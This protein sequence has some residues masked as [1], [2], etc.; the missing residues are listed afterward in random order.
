[1][2]GLG[3][4]SSFRKRSA[5][6]TVFY[7]GGI[8][9][10]VKNKVI[11]P[12]DISPYP[13]P[14]EMSAAVILSR[15]FN[16]D[17]YFIKRSPLKTADVKIENISWEIKSPTG[18]GKRNI[19]H[20]FSRAIKQSCN[21]VFDARRSKIHIAKITRELD[22]QF[23]MTKAIKRLLLITKTERVIEFEK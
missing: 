21:I 23:M 3:S 5:P 15:H 10:I 20:Q 7:W 12:S 6:W 16:S 4:A 9:S 8:I 13:K 1:M 17:V 11:V 18:K 2:T 19:Q 14:Y 22:R